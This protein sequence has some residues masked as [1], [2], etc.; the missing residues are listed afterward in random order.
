MHRESFSLNNYS[1]FYERLFF[2]VS[3]YLAVNLLFV[4]IIIALV[5]EGIREGTHQ[6]LKLGNLNL[7]KI[8]Y[9]A[10]NFYL[11]LLLVFILKK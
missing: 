9:F 8:I 2:D 3:F 5:I 6:K 1:I 11:L 7:L 4:A 10:I